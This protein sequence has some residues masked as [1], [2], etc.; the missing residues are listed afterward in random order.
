MPKGSTT[1]FTAT[2]AASS[3]AAVVAAI[4]QYRVAVSELKID[5]LRNPRHQHQRDAEQAPDGHRPACRRL[6]PGWWWPICL[7]RR[8]GAFRTL[9][10][11]QLLRVWRQPGD[12]QERGRDEQRGRGVDWAA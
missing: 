2:T 3:R 5:E 8:I 7:L 11:G 9:V 12:C 6:P 4:Q 1:R 10:A